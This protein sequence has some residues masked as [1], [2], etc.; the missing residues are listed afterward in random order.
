MLIHEVN[1]EVKKAE[2]RAKGETST[3]RLI[4]KAAATVNGSAQMLFSRWLASQISSWTWQPLSRTTRCL[5]AI[6][7]HVHRL[8]FILPPIVPR[9]LKP[10]NL[11]LGALSSFSRKFP[12]TKITRYTAH[13]CYKWQIICCIITNWEGTPTRN[14]MQRHLHFDTMVV[15]WSF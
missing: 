6:H 14:W 15:T 3:S 2:T 7:W 9:N 5:S 10:R 1:S 8:K 13:W 4:R 11:I 12:P